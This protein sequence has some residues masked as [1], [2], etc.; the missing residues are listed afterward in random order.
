MNLGSVRDETE[1][2]LFRL[3]GICGT[4]DADSIG[5]KSGGGPRNAE[6]LRQGPEPTAGCHSDGGL[7][8]GH[9]EPSFLLPSQVYL[10]LQTS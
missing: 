7:E 6:V 2:D 9:L 1:D 8:F 3:R 4:D 10:Q 5:F